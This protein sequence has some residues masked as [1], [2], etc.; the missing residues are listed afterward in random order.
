MILIDLPLPA[1]QQQELK[2]FQDDASKCVPLEARLIIL[3]TCFL[4]DTGKQN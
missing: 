4:S 2:M 3:R 1:R